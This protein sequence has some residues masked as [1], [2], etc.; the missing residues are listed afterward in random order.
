ML[1]KIRPATLDDVAGITEVHCSDID[2][3]FKWEDG[4]RVEAR[5]EE[6][7]VEE[8][9]EHGGPWMSVETCAVHLNYVLTSG[10]YPLVAELDGKIVGELELYIGDE[11]SVLGKTAFIDILFIHKNY[12]R[13]GIGRALIDKARKLA[14]EKH[15]NTLSVWP[16]RDAIPFY[17]KCGLNKTAF[18]ITY[19]IIKVGHCKNLEGR[20]KREPFPDN[21]NAL[22]EMYFISPRIGSAYTIWLK[23]RWIFALKETRIVFDEGYLPKYEAMYIIE[24]LWRKRRDA[25]LIFWIDDLGN[26][27]EALSLVCYRARRKGFE[28]L[29]MFVEK[30]I[31]EDFIKEKFPHEVRGSELVLMEKLTC[32]DD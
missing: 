4:E 10:Q 11:R 9:F 1:L 2:R 3:W 32:P 25:R 22:R 7:S 27:P 29:H 13:K 19:I 30:D 14:M 24:S 12:R 15:C 18:E 16:E 6:L 20:G 28:R 26:L 21:Y 31:Y 23:S 8:R 5:Y 17:R